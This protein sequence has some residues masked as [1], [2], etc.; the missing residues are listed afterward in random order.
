MLI[1]PGAV[2][3]SFGPASTV[4]ECDALVHF[5]QR[6]FLNKPEPFMALKQRSPT[7]ITAKANAEAK[8]PGINNNADADNALYISRLFVYPIKSCGG[9]LH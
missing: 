9:E 7:I 2:R 3:V 5:L 8:E 4:E 6:Q 1:L